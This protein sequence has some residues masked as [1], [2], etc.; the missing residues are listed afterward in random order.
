MNSKFL[1]LILTSAVALSACSGQPANQNAAASATTAASSAAPTNDQ[2]RVTLTSSDGKVTIETA[3]QFTDKMGDA[4]LMPQD[5]PA[6]KVKLLQKDGVTETV[7]MVVNTGSTKTPSDY[8]AKVKAALEAD[9]TLSNLQFGDI[10]AN[11]MEYGFSQADEQG[12]VT[13]N[14]RCKIWVQGEQIYSIC[15]TNTDSN[16][17]VLAAALRG[18][19]TIN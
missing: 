17:E 6:D 8:F 7:L 5:V 4:D 16:Q 11:S 3:G 10:A 12:N 19:K 14:E 1:A 9:K 15:A 13:L 18:I 2:G